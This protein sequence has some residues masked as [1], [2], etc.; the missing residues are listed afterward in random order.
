MSEEKS[1]TRKWMDG[2]RAQG[3]K[4]REMARVEGLSA[5]KIPTHHLS[6][7]LRITD[8]TGVYTR[9]SV[10]LADTY[11]YVEGFDDIPEVLNDL[12]GKAM[13]AFFAIIRGD[14]PV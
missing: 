10:P 4:D 14:E 2:I 11:G 5:V 3:K 7:K 9:E 1:E 12:M 8:S 6:F 13:E